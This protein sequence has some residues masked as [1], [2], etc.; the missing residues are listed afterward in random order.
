MVIK[1]VTSMN[2][3]CST[4]FVRHHNIKRLFLL[5]RLVVLPRLKLCHK[6]IIEMCYSKQ[7]KFLPK[8]DFQ[9]LCSILIY[10]CG[11]LMSVGMI[12]YEFACFSSVHV[13]MNTLYLINFHVSSSRSISACHSTGRGLCLAQSIKF[14][15]KI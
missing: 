1:N 12:M 14:S 3:C 15:L 8:I 11:D 2:R 9:L 4:N 10:G 5:F 6:I 7:S 13:S